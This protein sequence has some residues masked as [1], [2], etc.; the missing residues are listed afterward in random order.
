MSLREPDVEIVGGGVIGLAIAWRLA[1]AGVHVRVL[2]AGAPGA[3]SNAAAGMLSVS[4]EFHRE[5]PLLHLAQAA[6]KMYAD[7]VETLSADAGMSIDYIECGAIQRPEDDSKWNAFAA[8][9]RH[10]EELGIACEIQDDEVFFPE[11]SVVDP[12]EVVAALTRACS[13]HGIEIRNGATVESIDARGRTTVL[14]A[15]CWSSAIPVVDGKRTLEPPPVRP[16]KGHLIA[17]QMP[18]GSLQHILRSGFTYI[19][20]RSNGYTVAGSTLE[21][22]GFDARID[23]AICREIHQRAGRLW[24]ALRGQQPIECW[25]GLRPEIADG[26]PA[27]GRFEETNV[28]LAYGHYRNG[29]LLA[30]ITAELIATEIIA[31]LGKD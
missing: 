26:N 30:P 12:R 24:P 19:L 21:H 6:L 18:P 8:E 11:D 17:Y 3:A 23:P 1:R 10:Q 4:W 27:L 9:A 7:F 5:T 14:A 22:A 25:T 31:S 2:D 29:I 15:G 16:V 28:W 20:Q 13:V